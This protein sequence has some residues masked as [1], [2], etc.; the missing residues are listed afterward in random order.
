MEITAA[1]AEAANHQIREL[2]DVE[3]FVRAPA[4]ASA[5]AGS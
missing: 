2:R 1:E 3:S 4:P 5:S